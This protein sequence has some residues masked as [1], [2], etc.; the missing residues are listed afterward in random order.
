MEPLGYRYSARDRRQPN[1]NTG[2]HSE[3][4]GLNKKGEN[5]MRKMSKKS[6][7]VAVAAAVTLT[8]V[9]GGAA[10]AYWTTT[11]AGTG[12]GATG[13]NAAI[14]VVQTSVVGGL[15]PGGAAQ[16]LS[17]NFNNGNTSPVYVAN[18]VA[19]IESVTQAVGAVGAC[20]ATDYILDTTPMVVNAE[21][22][23]GSGTGAWGGAT[24]K[25][26]DEVATNQDGCK[27][28]TVHL[29]YTSN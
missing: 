25:F 3:C 29:G 6:R 13:T 10:F 20:D 2:R 14:S 8:A 4:F 1:R 23:S 7:I 12:S 11:G 22:P 16:T 17:G 5:L 27:G 15:Q 28:A 9:G 24:I 21:V 26:N 19:S 18:V